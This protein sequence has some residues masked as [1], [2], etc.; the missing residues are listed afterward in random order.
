MARAERPLEGERLWAASD[1][2]HS[3]NHRTST[4]AQMP[5]ARRQ[6][7]AHPKEFSE[8]RLAC[9]TAPPCQRTHVQLLALL[10]EVQG[11]LQAQFAQCVHHRRA[12]SCK[13]S[14]QSSARA[15]RTLG[16]SSCIQF[17]A[18]GVLLHEA[19]RRDITA[20]MQALGFVGQISVHSLT[21]QIA[22]GEQRQRTRSFE[23]AGI[24]GG[25]HR[26]TR[27]QQQRNLVHLAGQRRG[28]RAACRYDDLG[29]RLPSKRSH[30][31]SMRQGY[32][33]LPS[34]LPPTV[35]AS[36]TSGAQAQCSKPHARMRAR[37]QFARLD[38]REHHHV[39]RVLPT[40]ASVHVVGRRL[41]GSY[42]AGAALQDAHLGFQWHTGRGLVVHPAMGNLL[43][44]VPAC[45]T[46]QI[47]GTEMSRQGLQGGRHGVE[48]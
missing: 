32:E 38:E 30:H 28:Q 35:V 25:V 13:C 43:P 2:C 12:L 16:D 48:F 24:F 27:T 17:G 14:V 40:R 20:R 39:L 8:T 15:A 10:Y 29:G 11:T 22:Q 36:L 19:Q 33:G 26:C 23:Q 21:A 41:C 34:A 7:K 3:S 47:I 9:K 44:G 46:L 37:Q 4:Y 31:I 1:T 6:T 5:L 42:D 45:G 18:M